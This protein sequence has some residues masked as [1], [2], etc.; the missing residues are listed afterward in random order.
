M[1]NGLVAL[2]VP[3]DGAFQVIYQGLH[4]ASV[5][6]IGPVQARPLVVPLRDEAGQMVGGLWGAT[7][8]SWMQLDMLFVPA[9]MRGQGHGRALVCVAQ[10]EARARGCRDMLVDTFSFQAGPFYEKLGFV[11]FGVLDEL[12][13]GHRRLYYRK[14]LDGS[15]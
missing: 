3:P 4:D 9:R 14:R 6:V 12:P 1:A 7:V 5:A 13:P 10:A 2:D 11:Q 15:P 8:L